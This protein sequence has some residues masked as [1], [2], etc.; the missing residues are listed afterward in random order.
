MPP[1]VALGSAAALENPGVVKIMQEPLKPE[2]RKFVGKRG[3]EK[4]LKPIKV[5]VKTDSDGN[6]KY[7]I[8]ISSTLKV[9]NLGIVDYLRPAFHNS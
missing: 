9:L 1:I 5:E 3:H 8:E 7:P 6:I 4:I 2:G